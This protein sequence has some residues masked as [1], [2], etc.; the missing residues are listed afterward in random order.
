[1]LRRAIVQKIKDSVPD[2]A[3]RVYQAFLAPP[4]AKLPYVTVKLATPRGSPN[5]SF[6]GTQPVE[7]YLYNS[8]DSFITLDALE[9]AIA[10]VLHEAEIEDGQTGEKYYLNWGAGSG[11]FVDT[12]KK[13][14][15][16][17]VTFNAAL[18]I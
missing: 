7:V 1:M 10:A 2:L 6:A 12:E 5:I 13:L 14:I 8:Q 18:I 17:M 11:D 16:R 4:N 15:G 3:G 9:L